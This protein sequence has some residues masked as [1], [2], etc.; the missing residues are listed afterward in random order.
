MKVADSVD[1]RILETTGYPFR[2]VVNF[3]IQLERPASF[4]FHL[5]IPAWSGGARITVNGEVISDPVNKQ[6]AIVNREWK[7]GDKLTLY[8]PMEI[9]TSTWFEFSTAMERGPLVYALKVDGIEKTK[10]RK[11]QYREFT[12]VFPATP[13]NYGFIK[14]ELERLPSSVE[15]VE[16]P[17]DGTYP[18]NLE[19]APMSLRM[20]GFRDPDWTAANGIPYLPGFWGGYAQDTTGKIQEITLVPYGCTTLR[21]TQFPTYD[22]R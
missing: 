18:W 14:S 10:D 1:V 16:N 2:D 5:R 20:K 4:P 21:I 11:D 9:T 19:N 13:W 15:V 22:L 6:I 8:L 7:N 12:E 3:E 17:W